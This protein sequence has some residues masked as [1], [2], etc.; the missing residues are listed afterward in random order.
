MTPRAGAAIA[1]RLGT[2]IQK[3]D[4]H[5]F[6]RF[7]HGSLYRTQYRLLPWSPGLSHEIPERGRPYRTQDNLRA[8]ISRNNYP[9]GLDFAACARKIIR[10]MHSG[11]AL[12]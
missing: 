1:E 5:R 7:C 12:R 4:R 10:I 9:Q 2:G 6:A 8:M 11:P 3:T